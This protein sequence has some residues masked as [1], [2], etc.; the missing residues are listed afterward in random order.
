MYKKLRMTRAE[1]AQ[2]VLDLEI[3]SDS[4]ASDL[5]SNNSDEEGIIEEPLNNIEGNVLHPV[6]EETE[7]EDKGS[8]SSNDS[9]SSG[10]DSDDE[11]LPHVAHRKNVFHVKKD[12]E[13]AKKEVDKLDTNSQRLQGSHCGYK[14]V[15]VSESIIYI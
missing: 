7:S 5:L 6:S 10:S 9:N 14:V 8:S 4:E 11:R 1:A 13:W 3:P 12:R 2:Y 15:I